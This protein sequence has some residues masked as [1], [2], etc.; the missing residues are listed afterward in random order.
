MD[1]RKGREEKR[2]REIDA[3]EAETNRKWKELRNSKFF[4]AET[5]KLTTLLED[6]L[7]RCPDYLKKFFR[8]FGYPAGRLG[9]VRRFLIGAPDS[10]TRQTLESYLRYVGRFGVL[11]KRRNRTPRFEPYALIPWGSTFHVRIRRG[12]LEP[13]VPHPDSEE[14]YVYLFESDPKRVPKY[15]KKLIQS[16]QA[17]FVE[18]DDEDG[19]TILTRLELFAY[20]PE[21]ITFVVHRAEQPYLICLVGEKVTNEIWRKANK[22][23][24]AFQNELVGKGRAGRPL[25]TKRFK[26]ALRLKKQHLSKKEIASALSHG[27]SE[28]DFRSA[29]TYYIQVEKLVR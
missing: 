15:L 2:N 12:Q 8:N 9:S 26:K 18:I 7:N 13:I 14:P 29:Q 10:N 4:L 3:M 24:T 11:L 6:A 5:E 16:G 27:D 23:V 20:Y 25:D 1:S 22:A 28:K 21:G 19:S 17:K